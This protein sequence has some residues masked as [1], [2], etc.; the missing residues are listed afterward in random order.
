MRGTV[1]AFL[2]IELPD[3]VQTEIR[4]FVGDAR[5]RLGGWRWSASTLHVT[6]R[7]LGDVTAEFL[8]RASPRW[9]S[10]LA[11][12]APPVFRLSGLGVFPNRRAPR[13]LWIGI[14]EVGKGGAFDSIFRCL[15]AT[16]IAEGLPR[17]THAFHP[18]L[19]IARAPR[20]G[21]IDSPTDALR[22]SWGP[23]RSESVTLFRSDLGVGGARH[24]VL[25][26]FPLGAGP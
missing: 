9:R 19:T 13:V 1:R 8:E 7:F 20:G 4:A 12:C 25:E 14:E 5:R 6:I 24:T 11:S 16:C 10:D 18:H 2:A 15:E 17:E 21:S 22:P 3:E 23:H 26:R